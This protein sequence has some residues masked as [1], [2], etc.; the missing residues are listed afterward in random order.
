MSDRRPTLRAARAARRRWTTSG[1][2]CGGRAGP[3][4]RRSPGRTGGPDWSQG[5]PLAYVRELVDHWATAYDWRR[6]EAALNTH[7]QALTEVD[8]LDLHLL[9]VRSPRP[10]ARPLVITHGWPSSV[11]EPL[12][13]MDALADPGDD[14]LPAFHVVAPSLPGLRLRRLDRRPPAGTSTARPTP[15]SS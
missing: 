13:V 8:G 12:A 5:P 11:L 4:P 10:D 9:H 7:G 1:T 15:G 14:D 6:V 2:G 3:R